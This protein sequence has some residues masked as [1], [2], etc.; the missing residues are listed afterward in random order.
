MKHI[1][2]LLVDDQLGADPVILAAAFA[3]APGIDAALNNG[4]DMTV[5]RGEQVLV[6]IRAI[7][8]QSE[9]AG[10]LVNDTRQV[11]QAIR[12]M[13]QT[14]DIALILLDMRFDSGVLDPHG[15]PFGQAGD[16]R[17]GKKLLAAIRVEHPD[18]P[19]VFLSTYGSGRLAKKRF[20]I[21]RRA[22]LPLTAFPRVCYETRESRPSSVQLFW[23]CKTK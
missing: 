22:K 5:P 17:F 13:G 14:N 23:A 9:Q 20:P 12:V 1:S 4:V 15:R 6:H 2:V 16:E 18:L 8:G 11:L 21:C 10:T 7:S 3:D 19:V